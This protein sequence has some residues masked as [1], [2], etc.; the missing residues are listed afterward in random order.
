MKHIYFSILFALCLIPSILEGQCDTTAVDQSTYSIFFADTYT[1][2]KIPENA[3]DGDPNTFWNTGG[4]ANF[5]HDL[6]IDLGEE[7]VLNGISIKPRVNSNL[8]KLE[9]YQVFL[10]SDVNN[11]TPTPEAGGTLVYTLVHGKKQRSLSISEIE[12]P[13]SCIYQHFQILME[14]MPIDS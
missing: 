9:E 3:I 2:D 6:I 13:S 7:K 8:G 12:V 14:A 4:S 1:G 10:Y 5:P 11:P